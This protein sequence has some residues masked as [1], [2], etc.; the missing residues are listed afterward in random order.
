MNEEDIA[1]AA[2]NLALGNKPLF[3]N[4]D[5]SWINK[6]SMTDRERITRISKIRSSRTFRKL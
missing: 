2:I 5:E 1:M 3:I 6:Q 4:E